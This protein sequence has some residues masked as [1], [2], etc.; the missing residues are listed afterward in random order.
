MA[1]ACA[2]VRDQDIHQKS[3]VSPDSRI[4]GL[5]R[6]RKHTAE[7]DSGTHS[8]QIGGICL[9]WPQP[10]RQSPM[11][12]KL[13]KACNR[14]SCCCASEAASI[15]TRRKREH[16]RANTRRSHT[17]S[18]ADRPIHVSRSHNQCLRSQSRR[19]KQTAILRGDHPE[20]FDSKEQSTGGM[21]TQNFGTT[22]PVISW[23]SV[24]I[25]HSSAAS[26]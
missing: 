14:S 6:N 15:Y 4:L 19:T 8:S 26:C 2:V 13:V 3:R 18:G 21:Q 9:Q 5:T 22:R 1:K 25:P 10:V 11:P 17:I 23:Q 20:I 16:E 7:S 24:E 12:L